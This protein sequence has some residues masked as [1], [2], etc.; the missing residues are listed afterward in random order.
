MDEGIQKRQKFLGA[1]EVIVWLYLT[2]QTKVIIY[3]FIF[4]LEVR[5]KL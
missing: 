5:R 2:V 3:L 1:I 4:C